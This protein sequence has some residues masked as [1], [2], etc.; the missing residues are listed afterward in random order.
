ML[1]FVIVFLLGMVAETTLGWGAKIVEF[2][3]SKSN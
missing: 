1:G 3:K 2:I